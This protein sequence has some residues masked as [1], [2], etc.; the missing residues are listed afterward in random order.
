MKSL[1]EPA[2]SRHYDDRFCERIVE[3]VRR[4]LHELLINPH[5][6]LLI[7]FLLT[8]NSGGLTPDKLLQSITPSTSNILYNRHALTVL[9][10]AVSSTSCT[11]KS[12][13]HILSLLTN[14]DS[15]NPMRVLNDECGARMLCLLLD[16]VG[17]LGGDVAGRVKARFGPLVSRATP[18]SDQHAANLATIKQ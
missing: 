18:Q 11:P 4:Y 12:M 8:S 2:S 15:G 9:L 10:E 1:M 17:D 6:A 7:S 16:G 3:A 5:G 13:F 14:H